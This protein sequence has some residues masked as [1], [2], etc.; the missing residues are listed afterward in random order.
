[1]YKIMTLVR[2]GT[3]P[4]WTPYMTVK[5]VVITPPVTDPDTGSVIAPAVTEF[6]TVE[7]EAETL[8]ELEE[9]VKEL[10]ATVPSKQIKVVED[11]TYTIDILF[12]V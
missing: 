4:L 10:I 7:Y 6:K 3:K 8:D 9:A 12:T 1:M 2:D 5:E 11:L